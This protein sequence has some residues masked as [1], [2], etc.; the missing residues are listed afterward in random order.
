MNKPLWVAAAL[1]L[2]TL[3]SLA[4]LHVPP[5]QAGLPTSGVET[6]TGTT[7]E[8]TAPDT[9]YLLQLAHTGPTKQLGKVAYTLQASPPGV[10]ILVCRMDT[11]RT[12][13]DVTGTTSGTLNDWTGQNTAAT[14]AISLRAPSDA[15]AA[16]PVPPQTA[17]IK[18]LYN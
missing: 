4:C 14:Y 11:P 10:I 5:A 6:R 9:E 8:V 13:H 12:C 17:V 7:P 2:L 1:Y 16:V 18:L 15:G 3:V